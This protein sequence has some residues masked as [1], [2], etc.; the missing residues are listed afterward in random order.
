MKIRGSFTNTKKYKLTIKVFFGVMALL[1]CGGAVVSIYAATDIWVKGTLVVCGF[2]FTGVLVYAMRLLDIVITFD[3]YGITEGYEG[4]SSTKYLPY[5]AIRGYKSTK[6]TLSFLPNSSSNTKIDI[7]GSLTGFEKI[8]HF[9]ATHFTDL[10][11]EEANAG[12]EE[13][14]K[15]KG[16]DEA[17]SSLRKA[18][19]YVKAGNIV[20]VILAGLVA[21][22]RNDWPIVVYLLALCPVYACYLLYTFRYLVTIDKL[23]EQQKV[24]SIFFMFL[25][26]MLLFLVSAYDKTEILSYNLLWKYCLIGLVFLGSL[27]II[28]RERS[29]PTLKQRLIEYPMIFLCLLGVLWGL[30]CFMNVHYDYKPL[31][32]CHAKVIDKSIRKGKTTDYQV[33]FQ[34][35]G[36]ITEASTAKVTKIVYDEATIGGYVQVELHVGALM[37]Q[38]YTVSSILLEEGK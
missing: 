27:F 4:R 6:T 31:F 1:S 22:Y 32:V 12:F 30:I 36:P 15:K 35:C 17:A 19:V 18:R 5:N 33:H 29:N 2:V 8:K 11:N 24:P 21:L 13:E 34:A 10:D 16:R 3:D 26:P 9:A 20:T 25:I 7:P 23:N 14:V 38:Y 37:V 28:A